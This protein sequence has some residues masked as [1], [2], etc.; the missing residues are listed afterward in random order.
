[1]WVNLPM[2][3]WVNV[4]QNEWNADADAGEGLFLYPTLANSVSD[5][6]ECTDKCVCVCVCACVRVCVCVCVCVCAC[7]CVCV[8]VCV[9]VCCC[10]SAL[11]LLT[12]TSRRVQGTGSSLRLMER[13]TYPRFRRRMRSPR[14]AASPSTSTAA[15]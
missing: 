4:P 10:E 6:L 5:M 12:C 3:W 8:V 2:K 11:V 14:T 7:V 13:V 15:T 9:C 1:L